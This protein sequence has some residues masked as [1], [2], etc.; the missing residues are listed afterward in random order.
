ME[1]S[2]CQ[3]LLSLYHWIYLQIP[4][5]INKASQFLSSVNMSLN[6]IIFKLSSNSIKLFFY[7]ESHL[8]VDTS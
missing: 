8:L 6:Q 3:L 2:K 4:V 5:V 7:H 1:L